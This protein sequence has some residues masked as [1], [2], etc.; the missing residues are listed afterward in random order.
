M[1]TTA[2]EF[3]KKPHDVYRAA[4]QGDTVTINHDR[5]RDK[6]FELTARGREPLKKAIGDGDSLIC[7][8]GAHKGIVWRYVKEH[9]L[10]EGE[11]GK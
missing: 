10:R 8:D 4:D 6:V 11:D 9:P 2:D 5:Y 7:Q 3:R 1:K